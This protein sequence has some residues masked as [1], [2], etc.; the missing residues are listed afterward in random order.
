MMHAYLPH[1]NRVI[2]LIATIWETAVAHVEHNLNN[3]TLHDLFTVFLGTT[4]FLLLIKTRKIWD[5]EAR[6]ADH[7][8][9]TM[10]TYFQIVYCVST[11]LPSSQHKNQYNQIGFVVA[12]AIYHVGP[13]LMWSQRKG[14]MQLT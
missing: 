3:Y 2:L 11:D 10:E 6:H 12:P 1:Y 8:T 13:H 5:S 9:C 14:L 4:F 7:S